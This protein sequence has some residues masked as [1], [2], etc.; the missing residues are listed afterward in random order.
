VSDLITTA[1]DAE[2]GDWF[3]SSLQILTT[4]DAPP[5]SGPE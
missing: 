1:L 3:V 2:P 5:A 4:G